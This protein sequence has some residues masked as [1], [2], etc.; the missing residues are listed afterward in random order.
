MYVVLNWL[1]YGLFLLL[2]TK[3]VEPEVDA[4]AV[5]IPLAHPLKLVASKFNNPF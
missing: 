2:G 3:P 5:R 1:I 4:N